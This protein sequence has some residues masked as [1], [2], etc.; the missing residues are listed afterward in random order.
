[1][2]ESNDDDEDDDQND[3]NDEDNYDYYHDGLTL[4]V[5]DFGIHQLGHGSLSGLR[6]L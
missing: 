2:S 3:Q 4:M 6:L 5:H 1:M